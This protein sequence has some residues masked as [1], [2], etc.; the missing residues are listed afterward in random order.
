MYYKYRTLF[1]FPKIKGIAQDWAWTNNLNI[2]SVLLYLLSYLRPPI[3][4]LQNTCLFRRK[5]ELNLYSITYEI[6]V[7]PLNYI[8]KLF[9]GIELK[10]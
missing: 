4:N 1:I 8:A 3:L 10:P 5:E 6:I 2:F 9:V 7:L